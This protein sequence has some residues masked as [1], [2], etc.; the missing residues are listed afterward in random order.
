MAP[1]DGAATDKICD[2]LGRPIPGVLS[3]DQGAGVD[4]GTSW[5][6]LILVKPPGLDAL[7]GIVKPPLQ[8][9]SALLQVVAALLD[10]LSAILMGIPDLFRALIM[11]AYTLLKGIL[12]DIFGAGFYAYLDA[13][14]ITSG[15]R[16]VKV[17]GP[18]GAEDFGVPANPKDAFVHGMQ[19]DP[20]PV[21]PPDPF[22][23]WASRFSESFDDPGDEHRPI[24]SA[25]A[26]IKAVFVMTYAPSLDA[27]RQALYLL[28]ALFNLKPFTDAVDNYTP[29]PDPDLS[30]ARKHPIAPDWVSASLKDL[31]PPLRDLQSLAESL[32]GLLLS[33]LGITDLISGMVAA[34]KAKVKTLQDLVAV[35]EAVIALLDALKSTGLYRLAVSTSD[36][37]PGLKRGFLTAKNR[38][39]AQPPNPSPDAPPP[40]P[41][42]G[43]IGGVCFLMGGPGMNGEYLSKILG[44]DG[45][46]DQLKSAWE[47]EKADAAAGKAN[48][49]LAM[50]KAAATMDQVIRS[51]EAAPEEAAKALGIAE[52][53]VLDMVRNRP[54]DYAA[55]RVAA[56]D[57][58]TATQAL[59]ETAALVKRHSSRSLALG[60]G[61]PGAPRPEPAPVVPLP[62]PTADDCC[63]KKP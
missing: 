27:L 50:D 37:V 2:A 48:F 34:I 10:I 24:F 53:E 8:V 20:P 57:A 28:G 55:A 35:I 58:D 44:T 38:P 51:V 59:A 26:E 41:P 36:G 4:D 13:P 54:A 1:T 11:A 14:G 12:D 32:K 31:F 33:G 42:A 17:T 30:A 9:I 45:A 63:E 25:G 6:P 52:Q 62:G 46:L 3:D 23:K 16:V 47:A 56:G 21:T 19:G 39:G 49:D 7:V 5:Q 40:P 15:E 61:L 29:G 43:F 60:L 22:D 18:K